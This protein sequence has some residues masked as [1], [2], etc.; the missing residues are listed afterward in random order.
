MHLLNFG[1]IIVTAIIITACQPIVVA[2]PSAGAGLQTLGQRITVNEAN[3][4]KG[5][6]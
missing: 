5:S 2:T 1:A 4:I 6:E 3:P